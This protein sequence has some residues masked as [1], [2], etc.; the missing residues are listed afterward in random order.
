MSQEKQI[1]YNINEVVSDLSM[2]LSAVITETA[3][4]KA[5]NNALSKENDR[6]LKVIEELKGEQEAPV[7]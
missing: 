1:Q 4:L 6:L 2:K 7:E 5:M 3:H